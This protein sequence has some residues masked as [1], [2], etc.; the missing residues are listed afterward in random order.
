MLVSSTIMHSFPLSEFFV[1]SHKCS[2]CFFITIPALC[3]NLECNWDKMDVLVSSKLFGDNDGIPV[4]PFVPDS[5]APVF[6]NGNWRIRCKL[7]ECGMNV[8]T[9]LVDDQRHIVFSVIMHYADPGSTVNGIQFYWRNIIQSSVV[10]ECT[11]K[12]Q[13]KVQS[14]EYQVYA[15]HMEDQALQ[16]GR[17]E[18]GFRIKLF[19]DPNMQTRATTR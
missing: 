13:I 9:R 4:Q 19:S 6:E 17:L 11:Y 16:F 10:F 15:L 2:K 18:H 14:E 12:Q 7:G 8:N 3:Y 5:T 1:V